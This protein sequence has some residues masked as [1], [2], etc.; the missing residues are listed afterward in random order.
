MSILLNNYKSYIDS[1][2]TVLN[3]SLLDLVE[4]LLFSLSNLVLFDVNTDEY[5]EN[6]LCK[7]TSLYKIL[8][9]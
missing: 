7:D 8:Y 1:S 6:I 4:P 3:S 2:N 9:F 5:L